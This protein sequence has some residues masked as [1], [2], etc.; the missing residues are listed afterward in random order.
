MRSILV[1]SY[2]KLNIFK[3]SWICTL[4]IFS[5][6]EINQLSILL[7]RSKLLLIFPQKLWLYFDG[8]TDRKSGVLRFNPFVYSIYCMLS[9]ATWNR[10][11]SKSNTSLWQF[12]FSWHKFLTLKLFPLFRPAKMSAF[13]TLEL[14]LKKCY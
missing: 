13:T 3:I 8:K 1:Y 2:Q 6:N 11:A 4:L 9:Q 7:N 10:Q 14:H 12:S 5:L